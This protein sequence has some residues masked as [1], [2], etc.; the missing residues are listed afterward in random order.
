MQKRIVTVDPG[1]GGTGYAVW[2]EKWKLLD[3]GVVVSKE[4][5]NWGHKAVEI[6]FQL[7][8][9][10]PEDFTLY[11]ELPELH[12]SPGGMVTARSGALVKLAWFTGFLS[13][14]LMPLKFNFVTP[15]SW[16]GQLPKT[17][18]KERIK[19]ILPNL[20]ARS[21]DWDAVGIGLYLK[22]DFK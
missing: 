21:H 6:A 11:I 3:H 13:S 5:E 2:N 19:K 15:T 14:Y 12:Q 8:G 22:G 16:K 7:S 9:L 17:V 20:K 10:L 1:L 4:K 18:V